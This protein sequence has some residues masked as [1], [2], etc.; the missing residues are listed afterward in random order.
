MRRRRLAPLPLALL[1]LTSGCGST[2]G[3][4]GGA[5]GAATS[6]AATTTTTTTSA[7]STGSGG[8]SGTA[9]STASGGPTTATT[10]TSGSGGA[11]PCTTRI[12]YGDAWIHPP[13]HP[14]QEDDV[15]G[16]VTWD[17]SCTDD[18]ANSYATLSNGWQPYFN[19]HGGCVIALDTTCPGAPACTTRITYGA[20]WI[21]AP[22]HPSSYDDV[23]GRV[24]WDRSCTDQGGGSFAVLSNGW[25]PHFTGAGA[26]EMSFSY[27]D[28][29]GLYQNAVI[30]SGCADPGVLRDGGRYVVACTS[31]DDA[32][33]FP[34]ST[35]PDLVHWTPA[36]HIFPSASKPAWAMSDFWAPE[37]HAVGAA[38]V[39][40]FTARD[41]DGKLSVGA[42]TAT[43][44][45]GPFADIGHPLV[46]DAT[47]GMIDPTEFEDSG[48]NRYLVWKE[49]GNAVGQPTPI[50]GQALSP[51]G[52]SL[53]GSR[54]TLITNDQGWEGGVVEGPWVVAR[55]G[56]YYLFYSGNAY[57]NGS[58]A[59]GVA[60]ASAPL[61]PYQKAPAP[62]L[63]SNAA[64]IGPGHCSVVDTP[65]GDTAM[66]YHAW[67]PGHV[68]GPGDVRVMLVDGVVWGASFPGVPEAP[69]AGSRPMP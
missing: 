62:I 60:R 24:Y 14:S 23:P 69:S 51:D 33:A 21:P 55:G 68:N 10:T 67:Q 57:Y 2:H 22:N 16:P 52:T 39:A 5:G 15:T 19:G 29:G 25:A 8:A 4:P 13:S 11:G 54:V 41:V 42:A 32:D 46:H 3:G 27:T 65:A 53:V 63:T 7:A 6:S 49:D 45:L 18:G 66:I 28:C 37:I 58:Y 61:G 34:I 12:T 47:M 1:A 31:G 20:A 64:W 35:S 26:C 59:V 48:G 36:G 17:G 43:S 9:T 56:S 44:A 40:Y 50:Y 30:P 38:Y